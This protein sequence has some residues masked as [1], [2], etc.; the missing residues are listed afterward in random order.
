MDG[1]APEEP[2]YPVASDALNGWSFGM[3]FKFGSF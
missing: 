1:L 2:F 3:R